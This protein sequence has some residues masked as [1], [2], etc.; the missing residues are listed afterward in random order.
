MPNSLR[1]SKTVNKIAW[2]NV[3]ISVGNV[4]IAWENVKT[5]VGKC[6]KWR[7]KKLNFSYIFALKIPI[8]TLCPI[9]EKEALVV[10]FL[11]CPVA[12]TIQT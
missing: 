5:G 12:R 3:K 8:F 2:G 6:Q 11:H 4:K 1:K 9:R 10:N 7:G